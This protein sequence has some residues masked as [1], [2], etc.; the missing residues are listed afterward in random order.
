MLPA[1]ALTEW[2]H[3]VP[4]PI[5]GLSLLSTAD[6]QEE[7]A[8]IALV[9]RAALEMPGAQAASGYAGPRPGGTGGD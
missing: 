3:A 2:R 8:A 1:G 9:L 4:I 5:D 7:A 6:Q